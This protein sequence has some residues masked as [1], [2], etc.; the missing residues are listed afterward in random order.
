MPHADFGPETEFAAMAPEGVTIHATRVR[1][2]V[3]MPGASTDPGIAL[4]PVFAFA[5]PPAVDDAAELLA[6]A[7]LR[8]IAY[9]F[10]SSSYVREWSATGPCR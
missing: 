5:E 8:A 1:I 10:Y 7:P 9:G 2:N 3:V 6:A 4:A